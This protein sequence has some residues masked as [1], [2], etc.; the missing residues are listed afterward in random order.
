M[1]RPYCHGCQLPLNA[2]LCHHLVRQPCPLPV[3]ILQHPLE[4]KHA[5][6]TVPLLRLAMPELQVLVAETLDPLPEPATG[7]WWLLYPD[8][9]ALD[10]DRTEPALPRV[11]IGGLV[12]LDGTWRKTRRLLH[13]NPWLRELPAL[14]FSQAPT[15][16][17]AIR[18]G[19]GGQALSTLESLAHVLH[20]LSPEFA[21]EPLYRLLAAR[22]GLFQTH[23]GARDDGG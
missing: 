10:V 18:K 4:A 2:C 11:D 17:Y 5:K 16:A 13:L 9:Q 7:R 23:Q 19:P 20:R 22:V 14:S 21:P 15:G 1:P 8:T 12:V 6:S 3:L